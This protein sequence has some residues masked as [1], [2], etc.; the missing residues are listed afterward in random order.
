MSTSRNKVNAYPGQPSITLGSNGN[1]FIAD[2]AVNAGDVVTRGANEGE[3]ATATAGDGPL[4]VAVPG[5]FYDENGSLRDYEDGDRVAV[6]VSGVAYLE[7]SE[8]VS[9]GDRV[10]TDA[11]GQVQ[12][13]T[14][15]TDDEDSEVGRA[16][17]DASGSGETIRVKL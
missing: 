3:V 15:G 12:T 6:L 2:G 17:E 11:D 13:L 7:T 9:A 4:G 8:A 16:L 10:A 5:S 1:D 14:E